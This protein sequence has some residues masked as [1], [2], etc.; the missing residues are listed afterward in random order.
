MLPNRRIFLYLVLGLSL[1]A[2]GALGARWLRLGGDEA[3]FAMGNGRIEA[4]E[5][6]VSAKL[7][8]KLTEVLVHEGDWVTQ[9][10]VLARLDTKTLEANLRSARASVVQAQGKVSSAQA[11]VASREHDIAS[12]QAQVAQRESQVRLSTKDYQRSSELVKGGYISHEK[13]DQDRTAKQSDEALLRVARAQ[14]AAARAGLDAAR[15]GVTEAR[16]AVQAAQAAA[17][18]IASDVE[19][20]ILTAPLSGRVLYRLREPGEV[21][22]A[23]TAVLTLLD[24]TDVFMTIF[25]PTVEAG[26]VAIGAESRI[27]LDAWPKYSVP[28]TVTFVSPEAQFTPKSVETSTEREKL[29]FRLKVT[30]PENLLLAYVEQVKT[31]LP[32]VAWVRLTA[33]AEWPSAVPPLVEA[34]RLKTP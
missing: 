28:A 21:L 5:A 6:D 34:K 15:A 20:C 4:I 2:V 14:L 23:G 19:D 24:V 9:G 7:S 26:R 31:G 16:A 25:L 22:A 11:A 17:D 30:I 3:A 33:D 10:Q 29:M 1:T 12:A 13:M 27:V 32:G 18:A 8:G